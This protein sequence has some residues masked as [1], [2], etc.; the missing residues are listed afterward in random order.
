MTGFIGFAPIYLNGVLALFVVLVFPGLVFVRAISIPSFPQRWFVVFLS[1]LTANHLL[2]SLIAALHLDPVQTYR[3]AAITL[4]VALILVTV[5]GRVGSGTPAYRE[6]SILFLSDAG[7]LVLSLFVLGFAYINVWKHGIPNIFEG[8]DVSVSWNTWSLIWSQGKFPVASVGYPQFVPTIWAVT[9]IF[10]GSTEQ[11]FAFYIYIF[12]IV[13]P[14]VL[15]TMNLGR[16]GWWQPL[17]PGLALVWLIAEIRDPWLSSCLPQGYPDWVAAIFAFSGV[18]LF[19]SNA[20][21]GR[22]DREKITAALISLCLLSIAAAT[23]PQYGLFTAAVF[24]AICTEALK[25]LQPK[26]RTRLMIVAVGLVL[27]FAVAY[28]VY[29]LHLTARR[30]PDYPLAMSERL[31][32]A[33]MLINTNFT[34]PFRVLVFAG[35]ALSPFLT[36]VRWVALPLVIGFAAW[37]SFLSYDL[38]NLLGFLLISAFIPLFALA[39]A[40]APTRTFPQPRQWCVPD[41]AVAFGLAIFFVGLTISL[42]QG[43]KEFKQRFATDQL[44][45]GAGLQI[46]QKIEQLVVAGCTIFNADSYLQTVSAFDRFQDKILFFFSTLPLSEQ[47]IDQVNRASGCTSFFYPPDRT[48]PSILDFISATAKARNYTKVIEGSGMELLVSSANPSNPR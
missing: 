19:V 46:N 35:L 3:A 42:A 47:L 48:D 40:L 28:A 24:I 32:R 45:R 12:L 2:V 21:E 39:R 1:S 37:A 20:P 34:L 16:L 14:I 17:V 18:V 9:Y 33:L 29:H 26:E 10:T 7:W 25:Y 6:G 41:G 36:R 43:D 5:R 13:V 4:I 23:K 27:A 11:Y 44:S 8:G 22:F 30:I 15:I 31:P 38:R